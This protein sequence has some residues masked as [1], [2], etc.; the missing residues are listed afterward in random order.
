MPL[1]S[2]TALLARAAESNAAVGAFNVGSMEMTMGALRAAEELHTPIILQIAEKRL[3]H[4]P[5]HLIGPMLVEAA[6][7]SAVDIAVQLDHGESTEAMEQSLQY[8]FTSVM[9]DGSSLPLRDNISRTREIVAWVHER[10]CEVEAEIGVLAG[11]EGGP[12]QTAVYTDPAE[13]EE[14]AAASGCDALAIAI[15]NAHGHYRGK[16]KL[17]FDILEKIA[18]R[19]AVPLVLHGGSGISPE[20]FRRAISLG[21]RKI[22]I[23]TA[24]MD[25]EVM[26]AKRYL[27]DA[28]TPDYFGLNEAIVL[29]VKENVLRHINIF[30]NA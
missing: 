14:L 11:S 29:S 8:G 2:T 30:N 12:E 1:C 26:G 22:N 17:A 21:V 16:P 7:K 19:V 6:E 20:D 10:G 18:D 28:T 25:A 4:S 3:S 5:L 24:N 9:F 15:G 27:A 13:A 23:A